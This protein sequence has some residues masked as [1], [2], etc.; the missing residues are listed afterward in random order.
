MKAKAMFDRLEPAVDAGPS[1]RTKGAAPGARIDERLAILQEVTLALNSTL[2]PG[3]LL[4]RILDASIRYTG[5]TTGSVILIDENDRL[6]IVASRGLGSDVKDEIVL[7]VGEGITG[8]VA[9]NNRPLNVADVRQDSRYVMVKEHIRS[10]LAVPMVLGKQV[11]GVISVDSSKESNFGDEDLQV[12]TFV[13][14]QAAQILENAKAF[15]E[16]RRKNDQDATLLQVSKAL[17]SVLDLREMF[18][19][20]GE[21]LAKRCDMRRSFLVLLNPETEQLSIELAHGMTEE[22]MSRG[23]YQIG[24]GLTGGV[25]ET[26]SPISI[27]DI[28]TE[29]RFLGKTGILTD[30]DEQMGFLAVP[31][32]LESKPVGVLA[33]LKPYPGDAQFEVDLDLLKIITSMISQAVRIHFKVLSERELLLQENRLLREDLKTLYKFDNLV[34][35]SPSMQRVYS[36]IS[37]VA[38]SRSTALI[39]GES[40]TGKELIAHAIHFSSLRADRPFVKVNCA[41]I[42][43][44]LLEAELF[45]HVKGSFTGAIADRTGKFVQ[46]DGGTLFLDEIG[47]MSP[48]LQV[49]I[50]RVLQEKEV[51]PVGCND[52]QKVDV[53]IIAATHRNLEEMVRD[54]QFR[55]DLYYRLNVVPIVVPPLRERTEDI[56]VLVEHFLDRCA[57]DNQLP[58]KRVSP[59]ALRV[60]MRYQWPGNVRELENVIERAT[61]LCEGEW[62]SPDDLPDPLCAPLQEG[63]RARSLRKPDD[64]V[65][66]IVD[67][68]FERPELGGSVWDDVIGRVESALIERAL[69]Q[70]GGVRLRAAE[71]LGIHRNTLRKKL[72]G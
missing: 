18:E 47:D 35:S 51:E 43:E 21:I 52:V 9:Q 53:R 10:E 29:P 48:V 60:L 16:L 40:G 30:T 68:A 65:R 27:P 8:W 12:L 14:T 31:I 66:E 2:E 1:P 41:A 5:A 56:P 13:G 55:E 6:R 58:P 46:A 62:I 7:R 4:D 32:L 54:G 36:I 33:A 49:K 23:R 28:R 70:A 72:D 34:G 61:I 39:R 59:E 38:R 57:K 64:I 17:G 45:G 44:N 15:A 25:V 22:E 67:G 71:I 24:E 26:G 42:P 63:R 11:I 20:I 37:S 50:L 3:R 69:E 19:E